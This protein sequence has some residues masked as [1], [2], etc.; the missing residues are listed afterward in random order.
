MWFLAPLHFCF[1][2]RVVSCRA[3]SVVTELNTRT[4]WNMYDTHTSGTRHIFAIF[5]VELSQSDSFSTVFDKK[6][7]IFNCESRENKF[8]ELTSWDSKEPL[9]TFCQQTK[10]IKIYIYQFRF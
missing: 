5:P 3:D 10:A 4:A 1:V 6:M 2:H 7:M 9:S 8:L